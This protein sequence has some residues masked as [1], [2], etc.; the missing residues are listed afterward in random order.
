MPTRL[1]LVPD[2]HRP[3]VQDPKELVDDTP[4]TQSSTARQT[5][6]RSA[7]KPNTHTTPEL[8]R[9]Q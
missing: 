8:A 9:S 7:R 1:E 3:E 6:I 4:P 2:Q 5:D